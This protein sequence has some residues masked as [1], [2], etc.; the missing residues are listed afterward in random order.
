M[1]PLHY[2]TSA[3]N[4]GDRRDS[5]PSFTPF[6]DAASTAWAKQA[7]YFGSDEE[8]RTLT[9]L[10]LSQLPLPLGY[11]AIYSG[12]EQWNRTTRPLGAELESAVR[13]S[14]LMMASGRLW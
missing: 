3:I 10:V 13:P 4:W 7:I 6:K 1:L 2:L 9:L 14:N 12:G 11:I 8:I 5:N